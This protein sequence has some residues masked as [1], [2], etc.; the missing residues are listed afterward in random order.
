MSPLSPAALPPL[1]WMAGSYISPAIS[2]PKYRLR[3]TPTDTPKASWIR[4]ASTPLMNLGS[5]STKRPARACRYP[6]S[7]SVSWAAADEPIPSTPASANPTAERNLIELPPPPRPPC[8]SVGFM[9]CPAIGPPT[10]PQAGRI[11]GPRFDRLGRRTVSSASTHGRVLPDQAPS[12]LRLRHRQR[13]QDQGPRPGRGHHRPRHGQSR[14]W[15]AE[16]HRRQARRGRPQPAQPP[17]LGLARHHATAHGDGELVPGPLRGRARPEHGGHRHHRRQGGHGPPGAGRPAARRRRP[18]P[19]PD[20][21]HPRLLGGDR[22][23]RP[24]LGPADAG[25]ATSSRACRKR[26]SSRGRRPRCSSCPS[27]TTPPRCAWTGTSSPRSSSSRASTGSWWCTTSRTP[28]SPSTATG[29]RR[30]WTC[31]GAKDVGVEI[32]STSKSYNMAGLA[33]RRSCAATR[34]MVH[35][36]APH[37]V[38]PRL[39]RLPADPDRRH[40]RARGRS[41]V[42][43]RDRRG[44]PQA[45]RRAGQRAQQDRLE[46]GQAQGHDVR[47]GARSPRPFRA[48]GSLEFAKLLIEEAQG[49]GVAGHRL[50][51]VRG[52]LRA[53]RA[54]GERAA[55]PPGPARAQEPRRR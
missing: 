31:P 54:G 23:R 39:R 32:F 55:D 42:R 53:L 25:R 14:P 15:H 9:G 26:P 27:R 41:V 37:Q 20:L 18:R 7:W 45:P 24:A 6:R 19:E 48:L 29:R 8:G 49:R 17:V 5:V 2:T 47:L 33:A 46:R 52:G 10:I 40:H 1:N 50:R 12:A 38:V 16:A 44:P 13:P 43:G 4:S 35:A 11:P 22:R 3:L 51:R 36:L 28:T 21:P 34:D 30:S